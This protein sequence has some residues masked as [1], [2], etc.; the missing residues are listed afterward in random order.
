MRGMNGRAG[1]SP[2]PVELTQRRILRTL[3]GRLA[4]RNRG[5]CRMASKIF[6]RGLA[7]VGAFV[8]VAA[9][10]TTA[11]AQSAPLR[12]VQGSDG[13]LYL[14]QAGNSWTLVPDSMS[15]SDLS[16]L[17][18]SGEVD[19]TIPAQLVASTPPP[20]AA[21]APPPAAPAPA[22]PVVSDPLV[23]NYKVIYGAQSV[24]SIDGSG[25]GYTVTAKGP[26]HWKVPQ[27]APAG[28][29]NCDLPDGTIIATFSLTAGI[30]YQGQHGNW[31]K[32]CQFLGWGQ[33]Q[34][35]LKGTL[36]SGNYAYTGTG[37]PVSFSPA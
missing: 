35:Q 27:G 17:T 1:M 18:P 20:A 36:L 32:S 26:L 10:A 25:G 24:V 6:V 13:T 23:G 4:C 12:V 33:M 30:T 3:V 29:P 19:G 21:P 8:L 15:D 16:G 11:V 5:A 34:I 28:T 37:I 14:V 2:A 7:A 9:V 31:D 22:A